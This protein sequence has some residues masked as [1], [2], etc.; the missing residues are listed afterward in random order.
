MEDTTFNIYFMKTEIAYIYALIDPRDLQ[1][2]Y[3]GKTVN[4]VMRKY[5]HI[6]ERLTFKHR[7]ANWINELY[8]KELRPIFKILEICPLDKFEERESYYIS[9]YK[10]NNLTNSDD[11]GHGNKNRKRDII[12]NAMYKSKKVYQYDLNG[13]FIKEYKSVREASRILNLNHANITRSC[14]GLWKHT[15]GFIFTYDKNKPIQS[16]EYPNALKK[17]VIEINSDGDIIGEWIS[18]ME[19]SRKTGIDNGNLSRVCNGKIKNI[20]KRI[21]KFKS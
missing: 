10:S 4:P 7:K 9:F 3:I 2:R 12:E 20:K 16:V 5:Q 18:I 13:N 6:S 21:F 19:C 17:S 8:K 14:N 11:S 1:V 15:N